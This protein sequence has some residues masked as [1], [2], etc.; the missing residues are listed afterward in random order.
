MKHANSSCSADMD[1]LGPCALLMREWTSALALEKRL[2]DAVYNWHVPLGG[3]CHGCSLLMFDSTF[4]CCWGGLQFFLMVYSS[5]CIPVNM[6]YGHIQPRDGVCWFASTACKGPSHVL[7]LSEEQQCMVCSRLGN[8]ESGVLWLL[9]QSREV[10]FRGLRVRMSIATAA[11]TVAAAQRNA[12]G[13]VCW[14][15]AVKVQRGRGNP[16]GWAGE[17]PPHDAG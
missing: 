3:V 17:H 8:G 9:L 2:A 13:R 10:L 5:M 7:E 11:W 16:S 12:A 1:H 15:G 14:G 6:A 4:C